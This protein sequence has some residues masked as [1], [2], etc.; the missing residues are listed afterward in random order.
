VAVKKMGMKEV[1][2]RV[3][4]PGSGRES[5]IRAIQAA[6]LDIKMIE[7][8]TPLPHNGCRPKKRRRV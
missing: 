7:D 6:G 3:R 1:D 8:V 4:G 2:L 5:A